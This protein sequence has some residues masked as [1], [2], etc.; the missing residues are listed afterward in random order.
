MMK[1][2]MIV[3]ITI[4]SLQMVTA[5]PHHKEK[6]GMHLNPEDYASIKTKKMTLALDLTASQ[7]DA[8]YSLVLEN[9]KKRKARMETRKAKKENGE[10]QKPSKAERVEIIKRKLDHKIAM[11]AEVK[12]ILNKEQYTKWDKMQTRRYAKARHGAH[13]KHRAKHRA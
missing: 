3:A 11:K 10:G 7:Q 6:K 9:A 8:I 5:Q 4:L 13:K 2:L 12:K 1:K